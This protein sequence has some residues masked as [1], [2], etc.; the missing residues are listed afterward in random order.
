MLLSPEE[1]ILNN[2]C[3]RK[4]LPNNPKSEDRHYLRRRLLSDTGVPR[5]KQISF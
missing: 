2:M 3:L 1:A 5:G 4:C